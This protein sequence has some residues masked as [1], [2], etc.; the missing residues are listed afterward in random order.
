MDLL[1]GWG[2]EIAHGTLLTMKVAILSLLVGLC[3]GMLGALAQMSPTG[4]WHPL[5]VAS[6]W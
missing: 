2:D 4:P 1:Q 6:V 3:W 5:A